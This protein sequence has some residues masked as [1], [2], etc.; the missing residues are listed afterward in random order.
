MECRI[1][2]LEWKMERKERKGRKKN[3]IIK[4]LEVREGGRREIVE[5][6]I[7]NIEV[8]V[9]I[10]EVKRIGGDRKRERKM[11]LVKL[12]NEEQKRKMMEKKKNLKGRKARIIKDWTWKEKKIS[13]R[14]K[15]GTK[16]GKERRVWEM[17]R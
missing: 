13:W 11:V 12:E 10:E 7:K 15:Q 3:I 8:E 9:E 4:R 14:A 6:V 5:G 2:K 17:G 1:K 16:E